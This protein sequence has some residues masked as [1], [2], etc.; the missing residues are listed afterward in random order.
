MMDKIES[1]ENEIRETEE[2]LTLIEER[3]SKYPIDTDIPLHLIKNERRLRA[4]LTGLYGHRDRWQKRRDIPPLLPYLAN[5]R[6][7][8]TELEEGLKI[9]FNNPFPKPLVCIIHGDEFQCHDM[10]LLRLR[11]VS[12]PKLLKLNTSINLYELPWPSRIINLRKLQNRLKKDLADQVMKDKSPLTKD[13]K[14]EDINNYLA[15]IEPI[16]IHTHLLTNDWQ[17]HQ[18]GIIGELLEFWQNWPKLSQQQ[19]LI[20]CLFIKYQTKQNLGFFKKRKFQSLNRKI[21]RSIKDL[22]SPDFIKK[23]DRIIIV[24]LPKLQGILQ[25]EVES[26]ARNVAIKSYCWNEENVEDLI[27]AIQ[28]MFEGWEKKQ[29]SEAIPMNYLA[30]NLTNILMGK[31]I[32]KEDIT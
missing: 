20:I 26:W 19:R 5:R 7:Q 18:S 30:E 8:E 10:F 6:D 14:T 25:G 27:G 13:I 31:M 24:V 29:R 28:D 1:I 17:Q 21:L 3:V 2:N 23:F 15:S 32:V 9:L 11:K 22:S 16:I 4:R 12:L